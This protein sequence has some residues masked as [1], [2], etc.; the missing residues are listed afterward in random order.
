[1]FQILQGANCGQDFL[2]KSLQSICD[3]AFVPINVSN[4]LLFTLSATIH[5]YSKVLRYFIE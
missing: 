1:M 5:Y 4:S 3:E 2:L